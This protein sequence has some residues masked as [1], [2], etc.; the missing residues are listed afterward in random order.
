MCRFLLVDKIIPRS[1]RQEQGGSRQQLGPCVFHGN[2]SRRDRDRRV[3]RKLNIFFCSK[4]CYTNKSTTCI[5]MSE[6]AKR[7]FS[8][9]V[10]LPRKSRQNKTL[11]A[12]HKRNAGNGIA[13]GSEDLVHFNLRTSGFT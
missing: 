4:F 13:Q 6:C 9:F 12:L 1:R 11:A 7:P 5:S 10:D 2:I 3:N 8:A